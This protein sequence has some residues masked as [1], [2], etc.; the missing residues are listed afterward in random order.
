MQDL[1]FT[2]FE[3]C[4][5]LRFGMPD[6]EVTR[7]LAGS[8]AFYLFDYIEGGLAAFW[9]DPH[10]I[11][12]LWING[13]DLMQMDRLT[14]ALHVAS[15]SQNYGQAQ[16]GSLYFMD[17]GFAL[18]QFESSSLEFMFF[19]QNYDPSEPLRPMDAKEISNYYEAQT[20]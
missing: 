4:G 1:V 18:I 6:A 3:G 17:L 7:T 13:V 11:D 20:A 19:A 10:V 16:G 2:P 5:P 12:H 8:D 14:A 9:C 15:L